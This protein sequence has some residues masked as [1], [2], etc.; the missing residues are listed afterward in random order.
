M[1]DKGCHLTS[2]LYR[3]ASR[4]IMAML[5]EIPMSRDLVGLDPLLGNHSKKVKETYGII[6]TQDHPCRHVNA[7][8]LGVCMCV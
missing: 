5:H 7:W 2:L 4:P 3:M 8:I 6:L 1:F